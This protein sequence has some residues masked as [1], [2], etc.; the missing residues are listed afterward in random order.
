MPKYFIVLLSLF[1]LFVVALTS[2]GAFMIYDNTRP[3]STISVTDTLKKTVK[4]DQANVQ[5]V[6]SKTGADLKALNRDNDAVTLKVTQYLVENGISKDKIKTNK[7]SY[8]DYGVEPTL[9]SKLP[10]QTVAET[11]IDVEFVNL[12]SN[13][14]AILEKTLELGVTRYGQFTYKTKNVKQICDTLETEVEK[15]VKTKADNKISNIGGKIVKIQYSPTFTT[16]CDGNSPVPYYSTVKS[17][18]TEILGS[19]APELMTGEQEISATASLN[20]EYR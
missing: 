5:L 13:P 20:V 18:D 3:I 1:L 8:P 11:T 6:I 7:N 4:P 17:T 19:P 15:S 10:K 2:A 9:D 12:D 14:N 16:N